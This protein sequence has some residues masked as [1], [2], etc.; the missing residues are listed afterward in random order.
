M[1]VNSDALVQEYKHKQPVICA[2]ERREIIGS[3]NFVDKAVTVDTLDKVEVWNT[4]HF[5]WLFI[6]NEWKGSKRW[7]DTETCMR[8]VG[9]EVVYLFRT[10]RISSTELRD[11]I[12][13]LE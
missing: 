2:E 8:D 6:G 1:G 4:Y 13:A 12:T 11:K 5:N 9:V 3:L 7:N 10:E